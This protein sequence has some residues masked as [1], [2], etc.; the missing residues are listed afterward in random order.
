M[1][2][3]DI[4]SVLGAELAGEDVEISG[5]AGIEEAKEGQLTWIK[6]ETMT[7]RA[8][9]SS[10]SAVIVPVSAGPV[11]KPVLKVKNPR[12]GFARVLSLFNPPRT[13]PQGIH[14]TAVLGRN[15]TVGEG[16]YIGPCAVLGDEVKLG[17]GVVIRAGACL[18]DRVEIGDE[19][20][21]HPGVVILDRVEIGARTIIHS[22]SVIGADGFGYVKDGSRH[23]KIPQVGSV[24]IGEDVEIGAC[25]TIDRATTGNTFIGRGSKIDNLVQIA[26]N[27]RVG[28]DTIIISQSGVAGSTRIGDRVLVAAQAGIGQHL[29][30]GSDSVVA[31][32]SGVDK[33]IASGSVVSGYPIQNHRQELRFQAALRQVPRLLERVRKLEAF[34]EE[35][36]KG[37][38]A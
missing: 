29:E 9:G 21:I 38:S 3:S 30:I 28:E 27:V 25:V 7:G 31:S 23:F 26:H 17:R 35:I 20:V 5:I 33:D 37:T 10:A 36:E 11:N 6:D 19:A 14:P 12:L 32:R 34:L 18:G 15:V 16:V 2:L 22:N 24:V 1:R 4:A 13:F 8:E